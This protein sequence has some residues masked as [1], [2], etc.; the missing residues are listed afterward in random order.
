[1]K[2]VSRQRNLKDTFKVSVGASSGAHK[3]MKAESRI[4]EGKIRKTS[5]K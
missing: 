1:M 2:N 4:R 5:I 3:G